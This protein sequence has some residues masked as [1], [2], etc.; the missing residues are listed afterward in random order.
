TGGPARATASAHT[1]AAPIT[2][3]NFFILSSCVLVWSGSFGASL[4]WLAGGGPLA[5]TG[6]APEHCVQDRQGVT[7]LQRRTLRRGNA[8]GDGAVVGQ[9]RQQ[10]PDIALDGDTRAGRR[11]PG[12]E[13][14]RRALVDAVGDGVALAAR[15]DRRAGQ[16]QFGAAAA[17]LDRE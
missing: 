14:H 16:H 12:R 4:A 6:Q 2:K 13:R 17:A 10:A 3:P 7:A 11:H 8:E 5:G 9:R 15:L 1:I